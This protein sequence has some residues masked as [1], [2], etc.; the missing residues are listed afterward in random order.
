MDGNG[1]MAHP[2]HRR[3]RLAPPRAAE[4]SALQRT[5]GNK[6][7]PNATPVRVQYARLEA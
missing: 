6:V 5:A 2:G 4:R 7:A 3:L 1:D